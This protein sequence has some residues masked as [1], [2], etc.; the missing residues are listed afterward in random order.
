MKVTDVQTNVSGEPGPPGGGTGSYANRYPMQNL[1]QPSRGAK[2]QKGEPGT[3]TIIHKGV[4]A[5]LKT[6][7][8]RFHIFGFTASETAAPQ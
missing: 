3:T 5:K 2:G 7:L 8:F 6:F 4:R 1:M